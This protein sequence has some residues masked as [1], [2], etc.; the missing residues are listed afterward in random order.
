MPIGPRGS[1]I[2]RGGEPSY[3]AGIAQYKE[4]AGQYFMK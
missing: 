1:S 4:I 3:E 2:T